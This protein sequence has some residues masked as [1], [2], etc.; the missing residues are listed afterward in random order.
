MEENYQPD[1]AK[2]RLKWEM[3]ESGTYGTQRA[4]VLTTKGQ[5][6]CGQMF[7]QRMPQ[8]IGVRKPVPRVRTH[9]ASTSLRRAQPNEHKV[10]AI[11]TRAARHCGAMR[12][13]KRQSSVQCPNLAN[14][15][16]QTGFSGPRWST[17]LKTDQK[18]PSEIA[19]VNF[20]ILVFD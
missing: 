15:M 18:K 17:N 19:T 10:L 7:S 3:R 1:T 2:P 16:L 14:R 8:A 12:N 20:T 4:N 11:A 6:H 13:H 5:E 9:T